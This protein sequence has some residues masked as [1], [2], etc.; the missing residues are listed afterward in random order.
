MSTSISSFPTA[1]AE[2]KH[3]PRARAL[4]RSA[5]GT[6]EASLAAI[7]PGRSAKVV[8][9]VL[10]AEEAAWLGAV[11]IREG[12]LVTVLRCAPFGG[13]MHVRLRAGGELAIARSL[14]RAILVRVADEP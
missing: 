5:Q 8:A 1:L 7:A 12:E 10:D 11:G 3:D 2:Q 4:G 9:L 6:N 14:A 13:P